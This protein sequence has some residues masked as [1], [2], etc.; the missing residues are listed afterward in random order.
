[1]S[2]AA[3][4]AGKALAWLALLVGLFFLT[5]WIGSAIP[6][7]S[8]WRQSEGGVAIMLET[9]GIHTGIVLPLVTPQKDWRGTF[10]AAHLAA[11][12]RPYTHISVSWGEREVFLD[13]PTWA[14]LS[15]PTA[16][17]AA[18]GGEGLLHVAHYVR[19]APA[20]TLRVLRLSER[21]YAG[22]VEAIE[23]QLLP[24][25]RRAQYRG[26]G[27]HDVF[28]AAPGSYHLGNSCNQ[29]TS[30]RLAEAGIGTGWWT[31]LPSGVMKWAR[32]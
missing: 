5:A 31:P 12:D 24:P 16:L 6:R 4:I 25:E 26:Y 2:H 22:L 3:R 1:M 27:D 23:R 32:D 19:P 14:D 20:E 8:D 13:T 7:N 9:N 10:P 21:D 15:L 28:Y 17:R 11:P 30:D 29:W 18:I